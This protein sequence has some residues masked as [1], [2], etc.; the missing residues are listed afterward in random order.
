[1]TD[2]AVSIRIDRIRLAGYA[3]PSPKIPPRQNLT[4]SRETVVLFVLPPPVPVTVIVYVPELVWREFVETCIVDVP[5]PEID[6]G[7]KLTVTPEG[8][9][10]AD[11]EIGELKPPDTALLMVVRPLW[12]GNNSIV[13][14]EGERVKFPPA[15]PVTVN[16]TVVFCV[17]P[18]PAPVIVRV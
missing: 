15:A 17:M 13:A 18:P 11:K 8:R 10:L 6:D 4:T 1:M 3:S 7:L 12:P 2:P 14:G 5:A 16:E 9:P